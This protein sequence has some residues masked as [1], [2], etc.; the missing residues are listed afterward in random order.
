MPDYGKYD[1]RANVGSVVISPIIWHGH[2]ITTGLSLMKQEIIVRQ[3]Q[4]AIQYALDFLFPPRCAACK[5]SGDILCPSCLAAIRPL[6]PPLCPQCGKA[7]RTYSTY[8]S[9]QH[10]AAHPLHISGLR[11]VSSY[12]EPLRT[13]IHALKYEG[14]TRLSEPLGLLLAK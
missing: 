4:R 6:A 2:Q 14:N 12:Q 7:I 1:N 8:G 13:C 10:C 3:S 5:K 11:A 9:C